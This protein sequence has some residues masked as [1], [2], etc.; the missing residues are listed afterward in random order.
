MIF[1]CRLAQFKSLFI[2]QRSTSILEAQLKL[3]YLMLGANVF[4]GGIYLYDAYH[5]HQGDGSGRAIRLILTSILLMAALR[6]FPK[7]IKAGIFWAVST[8]VLHVYYR[9][10]NQDVGAD[11]ITLQAI[12]MVVISSFYGLNARWGVFY[13]IIAS[14]APILC[15]YISFRFT[16]LEP[17][18]TGLNDLY[19]GINFLVILLSHVYFHG[20]LFGSLR[21]K[22]RLNKKLKRTADS[23]TEFLSTMAHELRTPLNSVI[24]IAN[25]LVEENKDQKE[26]EHLE[27]LKFSAN[28]LLSLVNDILDI[29]KLGSGKLELDSVPF[30]CHI[31]I[32]SVSASMTPQVKEKSL[33]LQ[34]DVDPRIKEMTYDGDATRLS[35]VLYNL[36]GNAIK[37][38]EKGGV[39]VSLMLLVQEEY[40]D[41][42]GFKVVDTGI[43]ISES[44]QRVIFDPFR[45]ASANTTRKFG[46]TGLGLAIV[47]Q[48][49]GLFGSEI[50][51]ESVPKIGTTISFDLRFRRSAAKLVE[52]VETKAVPLDNL[53]VLLAE[54]NMMNI[55]FMRQLLQR[56]NI[57]IDV[58]ENGRDALQLLNEKDYD[59]ILMDVNMPIMDGLETAKCI[60]NLQNPLKSSIHIIA[61]TAEV[62]EDVKRKL[63]L[64]GMNDYLPKP[65]QLEELRNKLSE[66]AVRLA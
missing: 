49:I 48:L 35:Q 31:L 44:Q 6:F 65:F 63:I 7:Y 32:S 22:E 19:V 43:G 46:G 66:L 56:W 34:L 2:P 27:V 20:V 15:H 5:N 59:V 21:A 52:T 10:F 37:F 57:K 64:H 38:T 40:T 3:F 14:A 55:Y 17:L 45:Q 9:A 51:L 11:V 50:K 29:N 30:N 60:R 47:K 61:L 23:K 53:R 42:I 62:S 28:N 4:K 39:T 36:I 26:R 33:S 18:P 16:G 13:T 24:G 1:A 41:L 12:V 54:D 58:A 25:L 8:T